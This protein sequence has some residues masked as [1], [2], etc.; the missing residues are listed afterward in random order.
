MPK[1]TFYIIIFVIAVAAVAMFNIRGEQAS[2]EIEILQISVHAQ[3]QAN[4]SVDTNLGIIP[5]IS[6][7]IV[8][9][10]IHD[11]SS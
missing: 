10:K 4:Y 9:D 6:I 7:N 8:T 1:P 11:Q 5:A 2:K 3:S